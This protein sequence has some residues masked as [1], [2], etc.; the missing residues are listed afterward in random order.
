MELQLATKEEM[1]NAIEAIRGIASTFKKITDE[2]PEKVAPFAKE[3]EKAFA[4]LYEY[5]KDRAI[6]YQETYWELSGWY[7][8]RL[9]QKASYDYS[10]SPEW[11]LAKA[12]LKD[13]EE[14]L[15]LEIDLQHKKGGSPY[16][17][18]SETYTLVTPK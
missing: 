8:L 9:T 3:W 7:S 1:I 2:H 4:E 17:K 10:Y 6:R 16:K 18:M 11:L 5:A 15:K 12:H 13:I 14:T